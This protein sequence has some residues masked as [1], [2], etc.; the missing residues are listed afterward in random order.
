MNN[1]KVRNMILVAVGSILVLVLVFK[2][3]GWFNR[4]CE[5]PQRPDGIPLS[6]KWNG[7]CDGGYWIDLVEIRDDK[8]RFRIYREYA[9]TIEMDAD[10]IL[11]DSC[12]NAEIP[13]DT[14]ILSSIAIVY[15]E[16]ILVKLKQ[17]DKYCN[18]VPIYPAYGGETWEIIK[19]KKER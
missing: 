12:K 10:F 3:S 15:E 2:S 6:A 17:P 13:R 7:S 19:N 1:T 14:S 16:S 5:Q 11:S 8:Y 4:P 9:A 18:L